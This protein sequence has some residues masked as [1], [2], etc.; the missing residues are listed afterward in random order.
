MFINPSKKKGVQVFLIYNLGVKK[1]IKDVIKIKQEGISYR[2]KYLTEGFDIR[3]LE[4]NKKQLDVL[5]IISKAI[6]F[7]RPDFYYVK[8]RTIYIIEHFEFDSSPMIEH[9]G[10]LNRLEE[11]RDYNKYIESNPR[12]GELHNGQIFP[13]S[14]S[15]DYVKNLLSRFDNH[16]KKIDSY[17]DHVC[18]YLDVKR[19]ENTFV[20]CFLIEDTTN[21]GNFYSDGHDIKIVMPF[22]CKEFLEHLEKRRL[23]SYVVCSCETIPYG[24][25]VSMIFASKDVD[26]LKATSIKVQNVELISNDLKTARWYLEFDN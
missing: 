22:I 1:R 23:C 16:Y 25:P 15:D 26:N 13:K 5:S 2:I 19:E 14:N 6:P 12:A 4:N 7:D 11:S 18:D 24:E 20:I 9:G 3:Y 8:D 21:F 10:S 17:I